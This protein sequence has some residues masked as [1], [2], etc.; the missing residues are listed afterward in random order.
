MPY[1]PQSDRERVL[2]NGPASPG[3]LNYAI[4]KLLTDY[5][6]AAGLRYATINDCLGALMG[7]QQEFYRRVAVPYE[8]KKAMENGDVYD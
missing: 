8:D 7:A 6:A 3:E 5:V 4:T 1:I 2:M